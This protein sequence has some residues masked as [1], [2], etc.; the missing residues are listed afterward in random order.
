MLSSKAPLSELVV[1][2]IE[3]WSYETLAGGG[4]S[5]RGTRSMDW[6]GSVS[7][8]P[9]YVSALVSSVNLPKRERIHAAY[10]HQWVVDN[11]P[12]TWCYSIIE[13]D[14]T[15]WIH[16]AHSSRTTKSQTNLFALVWEAT[17]LRWS[18]NETMSALGSILYRSLAGHT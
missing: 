2:I 13:N 16:A 14:K 11:M 8:P 15:F 6:I 4:P 12:V 5:D 7:P 10:T 17:F 3:F 9:V 18:G 1:A